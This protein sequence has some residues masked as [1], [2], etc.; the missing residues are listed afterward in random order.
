MFHVNMGT[1]Q[2]G[3]EVCIY[4]FGKNPEFKYRARKPV[5]I[6]VD[7]MDDC[8]TRYMTSREINNIKNIITLILL[9]YINYDN[10]KRYYQINNNNNIIK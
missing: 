5:S 6:T 8:N 9:N 10:I 7:R 2:G 3:G 1:S 4:L